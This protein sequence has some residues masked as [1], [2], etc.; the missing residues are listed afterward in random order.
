MLET[1]QPSALLTNSAASCEL[2]ALPGAAEGL[3]CQ[4]SLPFTTGSAQTPSRFQAASPHAQQR[5]PPANT[6]QVL[7]EQRPLE[8]R[9]RAQQLRVC[10]QGAQRSFAEGSQPLWHARCRVRQQALPGN[11]TLVHVKAPLWH[12]P[13]PSLRLLAAEGVEVVNVGGLV[14]DLEVANAAVALQDTNKD[15]SGGC[16]D[17]TPRAH[18]PI[19]P[20]GLGRYRS[21]PIPS[22][23]RDAATEQHGSYTAFLF[24]K[25]KLLLLP[26]LMS[27]LRLLAARCCLLK[28]P[29]TFSLVKKLNLLPQFPQSKG[30]IP[31]FQQ[32]H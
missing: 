12:E 10:Q 6:T 1:P 30:K 23:S 24:P 16:G 27:H 32:S 3:S 31:A 26:R 29:Y 14:R 18:A 20:P 9:P 8:Q 13:H 25:L 5:R 7:V 11:L 15:P 22:P 19:F 21:H 28:Y 17:S 2:W 4:L